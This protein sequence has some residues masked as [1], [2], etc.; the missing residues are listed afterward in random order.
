MCAKFNACEIGL[1]ITVV[2]RNIG[3]FRINGICMNSRR[4]KKNIAHITTI[5]FDFNWKR[6]R[7][8]YVFFFF[9]AFEIDIKTHNQFFKWASNRNWNTQ[10]V[11]RKYALVL[12]NEIRFGFCHWFFFFL[13]LFICAHKHWENRVVTWFAM[14]MCMEFIREINC[15]Q[16]KKTFL[17]RNV[18]G[19]FKN[20]R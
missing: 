8:F 9:F 1:L 17:Y 11:C 20:K 14:I 6:G 3:Y 5:Y 4:K 7:N 10:F 12:W 18:C 2:S 19:I 13:A 15:I 16:N